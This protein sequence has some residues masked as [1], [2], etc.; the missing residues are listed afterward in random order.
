MTTAIRSTEIE[1]SVRAVLRG[2]AQVH[3]VTV[4]IA[5]GKIVIDTA[6][7]PDGP[8]SFDALDFKK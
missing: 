6:P 4:D 3:R 5:E 1:K 8:R 2:G 7:D